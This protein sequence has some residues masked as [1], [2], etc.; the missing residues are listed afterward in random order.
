MNI[1]QL[2]NSFSVFICFTSEILLCLYWIVK[3]N[4]PVVSSILRIA[5]S[6]LLDGH[7]RLLLTWLP[8]SQLACFLSALVVLS[9]PQRDAT[10]T[11]TYNLIGYLTHV[12]I[13]FSSLVGLYS[14]PRAH[15][16]LHVTAFHLTLLYALTLR[17]LVEGAGSEQP[18]P[19]LPVDRTWRWLN[20][21]LHIHSV[22]RY[23]FFITGHRFEFSK[24][25]VL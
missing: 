18:L 20:C 5:T 21:Y 7:N 24:L 19:L 14:G 8:R 6:Q 25:Q 10:T 17:A 15:T 22:G 1:G 3:S 16:L 4:H 2:K 12:G 11:T 23:L 13:H 9:I